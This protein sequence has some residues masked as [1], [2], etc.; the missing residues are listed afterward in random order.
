MNR[1]EQA[2]LSRGVLLHSQLF[3]VTSKSA[4]NTQPGVTIWLAV[5]GPWAD[6]SNNALEYDVLVSQSIE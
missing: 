3:G 4:G 5:N 1:T 6:V 2:G